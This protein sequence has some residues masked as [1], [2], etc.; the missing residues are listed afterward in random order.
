MIITGKAKT[1]GCSE[2]FSSCPS[3]TGIEAH[4][5]TGSVNQTEITSQIHEERELLADGAAHVTDIGFK[6]KIV[7]CNSSQSLVLCKTILYTESDLPLVIDDIA[8]FRIHTEMHV[9]VINLGTDTATNPNL[10]VC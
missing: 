7:S 8:G 4:C 10:G 3:N 2:L 5:P 1:E 6:G 9:V